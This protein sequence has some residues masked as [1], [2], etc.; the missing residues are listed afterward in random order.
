ML[1]VEVFP[2]WFG[3]N[4]GCSIVGLEWPCYGKLEVLPI[5]LPM[6]DYPFVVGFP[7]LESLISLGNPPAGVFKIVM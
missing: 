3:G 2:Y 7:S 4:A 5:I 6:A 1:D